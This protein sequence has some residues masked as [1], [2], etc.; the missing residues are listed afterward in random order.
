MS[1]RDVIQ[2]IALEWDNIERKLHDD[3]LWGF[4][5]S[6]ANQG[7]EYESRIEYLLDLQQGKTIKDK[8]RYFYTFNAYL[9]SYRQRI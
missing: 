8:E 1:D 2:K 6:E 5:Y 4:I 3:S 9:H 7:L